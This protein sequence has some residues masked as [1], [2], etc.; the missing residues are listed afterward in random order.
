MLHMPKIP[1]VNFSRR[2]ILA[3]EACKDDEKYPTH[4]ASLE[5]FV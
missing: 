5:E 1:K 4:P 3:S 2:S